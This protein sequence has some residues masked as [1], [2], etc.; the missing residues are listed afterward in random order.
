MMPAVYRV[1]MRAFESGFAKQLNNDQTIALV[2]QAIEI[3][4]KMLPL[5]AEVVKRL[6]HSS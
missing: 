3:S 6:G 4:K 1:G 5:A 2:E